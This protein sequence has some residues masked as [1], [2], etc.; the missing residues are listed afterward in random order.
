MTSMV[1]VK[2]CGITNL[3]DAL[4]AIEYGADALGFI[5]APSPR[6]VDPI[7]VKKIVLKLPPF[8]TKVGVFMDVE[9]GELK[10]IMGVAE[11]DLAQLHGKEGPDVCAELFPRVIKAFNPD[12]L[13]RLN[14]LSQ[15]Q[16]TAFLLDK[17]KGSDVSPEQLWPIAQDM[18]SHGSVILAGALTPENVAAAI[19]IAQPYAVD[20]ASGVEKEPGKK[21]HQKMKDFIRAAKREGSN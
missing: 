18:S 13:P 7:E 4:A 2:I 10:E 6:Q 3:D 15:Y 14:E 11:I 16:V 12:T 8:I 9:I 17:Q 20:V 1:K 5:F 21:D 19:S